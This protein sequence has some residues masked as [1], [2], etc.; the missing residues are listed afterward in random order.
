MRRLTLVLL[1]VLATFLGQSRPAVAAP[2]AS[3]LAMVDR[4]S[5]TIVVGTVHVTATTAG[6]VTVGILVD[7]VVRGVA[8]VGTTLPA[9]PS[10]DG[11]ITIDNE[12]VLAFIDK[13]GALR[14][15]GRLVAGRSIEAGVLK[16]QGFFD[17]NAHIVHPG[18]MTLAQLQAYMSTHTLQQTFAVTLAFPD[19]HGAFAPA[20]ARKFSVQYDALTRQVHATGLTIA[21]LDPRWLFGLEWGQFQLDLAD[22]CLTSTNKSR[23]LDFE[24]KFTG[25]D[26]AGAITVEAVPTRPFLY[27]AEYDQFARDGA[28]VDV[29]RVVAVTL[30]GGAVWS[31][32]VE[33]SLI[34]PHGHSRAAGGVSSSQSMQN[35]VATSTDTYE[36]GD[37]S[38]VISP[39]PAAASPGGNPR[40]L[41]SLVDSPTPARCTFVQRGHGGVACKLVRIAPIFTR[42]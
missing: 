4:E 6:V 30:P 26:A 23:S 20:P 42:R 29:T 2:M 19:G 17:F 37:V 41:V 28:I 1:L 27:E 25:V 32:R 21:C 7:K 12:R 8:T 33:S 39:S 35:G 40:A 22:T 36:F 10:P 31:W 38:I 3:D 9:H 14:W 16:L 34:D 13:S 18:L 15:V 5:A 24:G 11:H